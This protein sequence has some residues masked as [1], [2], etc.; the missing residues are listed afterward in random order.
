[1]RR[2]I[3][4][5][6]SIILLGLA[7][8]VASCSEPEESPIVGNWKVIEAHLG[9]DDASFKGDWK[10][11]ADGTYYL[12]FTLYFPGIVGSYSGYSSGDYRLLS[13]SIMIL[14]ILEHYLPELNLAFRVTPD[15]LLIDLYNSSLKTVGARMIGPS[16]YG[17]YR[18]HG[19]LIEWGRQ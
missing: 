10:I 6:S 1:M 15:T 8:M 9:V 7:A 18:S 4:L 11:S 12:D 17:Q 3:R 19:A 13:D 2:R 16:I 5:L 14:T